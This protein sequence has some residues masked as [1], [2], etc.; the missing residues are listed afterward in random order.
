MYFS[1]CSVQ[2]FL[3][4]IKDLDF[5]EEYDVYAFDLEHSP[6]YHSRKMAL[7]YMHAIVDKFKEGRCFGG[8]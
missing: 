7:G 8:N 2:L 5:L 3:D 1:I 6:S 4:F